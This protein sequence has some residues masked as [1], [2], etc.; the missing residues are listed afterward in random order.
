MRR[1]LDHAGGV[2]HFR[3]APRVLEDKCSAFLVEFRLALAGD[4]HPVGQGNVIRARAAGEKPKPKRQQENIFH[5][6]KVDSY[7]PFIGNPTDFPQSLLN[8]ILCLD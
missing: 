7:K 1:D 8:S 3:F 2:D 4:S 5:F 6:D